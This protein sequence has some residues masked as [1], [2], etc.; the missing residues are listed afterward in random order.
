MLSTTA[1]LL[2]VTLRACAEQEQERPDGTRWG[3]VYLDNARPDEMS[4]RA[5]AGYLSALKNADLYH[6]LNDDCFGYVKLTGR[7]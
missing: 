1:K 5:F 2:L 3:L 7:A 4:A 6:S